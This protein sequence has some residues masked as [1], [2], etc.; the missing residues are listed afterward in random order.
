LVEALA[1]GVS[2]A[3]ADALGTALWLVLGFC[4]V[5]QFG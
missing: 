3:L 4:V 1:L 2:D 5:P